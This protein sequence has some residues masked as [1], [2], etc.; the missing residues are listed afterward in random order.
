MSEA[1]TPN[2]SQ[3]SP[4]D[5]VQ[6]TADASSAEVEQIESSPEETTPAAPPEEAYEYA[7]TINPEIQLELDR[8]GRHVDGLTEAVL[9]S[10]DLASRSALAATSVGE[11]LKKVLAGWNEVNGRN[12]FYLKILVAVGGVVMFLSSVMFT[13]SALRVGSRASELD[14]MLLAVGKRV[15]ELNVATQSV[16]TL[17]KNIQDFNVKQE[18]LAAAQERLE[19]RISESL[20]QTEAVIKALPDAT[21]KQVEQTNGALAKQ[22]DGLNAA[23][24]S[25]AAAVKSLSAQVGSMG[26]RVGD[27]GKL[28]K[29]VE[30]MVTLQR[31]RYLETLQKGVQAAEQ[32]NQAKPL[33]YPRVQAEPAKP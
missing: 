12:I 23:L 24:A 31:E 27:V 9:E 29:E 6:D 18:S 4:E 15:V 33:S 8:F 28:K 13:V 14:A 3:S 17:N 30:A 26:G 32:K 1:T 10:A 21:A 5:V 16:E 20:S 2:P 25:Q 7:K 22:V 11:E 19:K